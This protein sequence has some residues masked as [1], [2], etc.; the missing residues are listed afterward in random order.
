MRGELGKKRE[1]ISVE[2]V[3]LAVTGLTVG[4]GGEMV[5]RERCGRCSLLP[6]FFHRQKI[7]Y[8]SLV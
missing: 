2:R 4:G 1:N 8:V 6:Q 7:L 3:R 5:K